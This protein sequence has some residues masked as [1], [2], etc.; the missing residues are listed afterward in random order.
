MAD[1]GNWFGNRSP[2]ERV[3]S[4]KAGDAGGVEAAVCER[5]DWCRGWVSKGLGGYSC[6][7]GVVIWTLSESEFASDELDVRRFNSNTSEVGV[8]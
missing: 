6:A 5:R 2:P 4:A 7:G 3:E 1:A 8:E